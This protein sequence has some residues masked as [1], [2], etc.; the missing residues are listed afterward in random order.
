[1]S[2]FTFLTNE[3][4][5]L[6]ANAVKSEIYAMEDPDVSAICARKA[7]ETSVKFIY[8]V[9][10][11]LDERQIKKLDLF[12]LVDSRDFQD[13][14]PYELIDEIHFVRKLGNN[15]A[16]NSQAISTSKSL[17]ANKC[18]Y[19][20][21]RWIVEVYS[22][23]DVEGEYDATKLLPSSQKEQKEELVAQHEDVA[24]LEAEN[25]KLLEELA[26][27][28]TQVSAP[29]KHV[30]KVATVTEAQTRKE[31]IDVELYEAGYDVDAFVYGVDEEYEV[32]LEEGGKGYVD[33]VIW[34][35]DAKP[36][37]VIEAKKTIKDVSIGRHQ[38]RRYSEALREEFG[39]D[40][41]TF[42]TNGRVIEY[43]DGLGGF[44][45]IHSI[46][47]K[48]E[49]LRALQKKKAMLSV[50]PST[51]KVDDAITDRGYQKRVIASVLK[52]YE[53]QQRRALL[54]M[55][56]GTGKTR[57]S[58]SISDVLIRAGW[59]RKVLFLADRK[60]LVKQATNNYN[61]YLKETCVNLVLEK[62]DLDN[63]M[64]FGTYETVHNLIMKGKYNSAYFDLVVVDEAHR[65]IYKK[66][67]AIF[68]YFD[69]FVLGLTATPADEVHRNTYD[70][71]GTAEGDPTDSYDLARAIED[72][73]L[74]D[75]KPYEIDLG[76]VTRG[77]KYDELSDE[78]KEEFEDK[79]DEEEEEISASEINQRVLNKAT[80]EKVL[81]YLMQHGQ[82][83][84][85]GNK[86][87]KTII[88]SK[89]KK[90]AEY[91]KSVYD[92]LYPS[93]ADEAQIIHSE[94]AHVESLI[95]NFK[96]PK[97]DPQIA[98][99]VDMLDTGID[100]PELLNLVFFKPIKSKIKF[101]Q[102]IG[103]GT[104]LCP[105][106]LG[107]GKD[108]ES[109]SIFDFCGNF[110]Y[111]DIKAEGE[112]SSPSKSLKERL[113]LKRVSLLESLQEG[114]VKDAIKA[115]VQKQIDALDV[116]QYHLKGVRHTVEDLHKAD[117]DYLTDETKTLLKDVSE[118][119][120]DE[121]DVEVQRYEMLTLNAQE[122]LVKG[123]ESKAYVEQI[124]E[125]CFILKSKAGNIA[126]VKK[127]ESLIDA[128]LD[129]TLDLEDVEK[130]EG[131]K[132][133][134]AHLANLSLGKRVVPVETKFSDEIEAVRT[135]KSEQFVDKA[136]V[137]TEVQKVLSAYLEKLS[138]IKLIQEANLIT[139]ADINDLKHQVFDY[140][141][142]VE[143]RL[144]NKDEF[145]TLMQEV[146]NSSRK[147]IA[148]K[149]F[150]NY[151]EA[152][153]YTQ[154]QIEV[155]N[156]IKNILF[157]KQYA[158][159][160]DSLQGVKEDLTSEIHPL[161]TVFERLSEMEQEMIVELIALLGTVE[162]AMHEEKKS[163]SMYVV[164]AEAD[165]MMMVAEPEQ[166][167]KEK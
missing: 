117:L 115:I 5:I 28:K 80:N 83:I 46:F 147:E 29:Q 85:E 164:N 112:P 2:N 67:R 133:G 151:I 17:Y 69:A 101:W 30:V 78:E 111:F 145:A 100:I 124:K 14:L 43:S 148:N 33:Y 159:L 42:V 27:L 131:L 47:P 31:L 59:V 89:N 165:E 91:I 73:N 6:K 38:A 3:F 60:E 136:S 20:L 52:S 39:C 76:I 7:L 79:F 113:F 103:R 12:G 25:A 86:I 135:L 163:A 68:E 55:A 77:I 95:D 141:K 134:I 84:D 150:D 99:S 97:R 62:K 15:A 50:K 152:G 122:A 48:S 106:L 72:G 35:E 149:I 8:R 63:R 162:S 66:Y 154:K 88:F 132:D 146:L 144:E 119:V 121:K 9:D 93:K 21:Q 110:T 74:V 123:K 153:V 126:A 158:T 49:M 65:T 138:H 118:Y 24:N 139:D 16:H 64:H 167:Y 32:T 4:E 81:Q 41:L 130:L 127:E 125:R 11:S 82:K 94:I 40:V 37:A 105:N 114:S 58:A 142:M 160:E 53:A 51:L 57:V 70:F 18:L 155:S 143:D 140:E 92:L 22:T 129:G 10:E 157:G 34:G 107:E 44:R 120:E 1:M 108:K 128:V 156:R 54:V 13:I 75:F 116:S 56:T 161:A 96:N 45:Q 61:T 109:F 90:H 98:I 87:G 19:K 102:M 71:F 104:R 36:L 23:Y 26:K 137:Q 166:K